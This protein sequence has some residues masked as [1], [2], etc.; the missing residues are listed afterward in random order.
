[1]GEMIGGKQE[2]EARGRD[3]S[4]RDSR[5]SCDSGDGCDQRIGGGS[6]VSS[7]VSAGLGGTGMSGGHRSVD[8]GSAEWDAGDQGEASGE[9]CLRKV[10]VGG[11]V[12]RVSTSLTQEQLDEAA[13]V[14]EKRARRVGGRRGVTQEALVLSAIMSEVELS[15]HKARA[16]WVVERLEQRVEELGLVVHRVERDNGDLRNRLEFVQMERDELVEEVGRMKRALEASLGVVERALAAVS[17]GVSEGEE[18]VEADS[19]V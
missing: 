13:A 3:V 5:D 15:R 14:V 12:L 1:M 16:D 19:E 9:R 2:C 18:G 7:R 6:V 17:D 11:Q 10:E 4:G 8:R